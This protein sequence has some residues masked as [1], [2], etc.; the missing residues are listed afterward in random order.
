MFGGFYWHLR[1][2]GAGVLW[3]FRRR[4]IGAGP[5]DGP[6]DNP[7]GGPPTAS[8]RAGR[9]FQGNLVSPGRGLCLAWQRPRPVSLLSSRACV[10]CGWR[11]WRGAVPP[12][13]AGTNAL[14][15]CGAGGEERARALGAQG[16]A[17]ESED[18]KT[19]IKTTPLGRHLG[20]RARSLSSLSGEKMEWLALNYRPLLGDAERKEAGGINI[21]H[22]D[23]KLQNQ[24]GS[25]SLSAQ[26]NTWQEWPRRR[27]QGRKWPLP[28]S[29]RHVR[30]RFHWAGPQTS[31]TAT[32]T[33]IK[34]MW[35]Y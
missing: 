4:F 27:R 16:T 20:N 1:Q 28:G 18:V 21:L 3:A 2:D 5:P 35:F 9:D 6:P 32:P 7:P 31:R 30:P 13:A 19:Q 25:S 14:C 33:L 26:S 22:R 34:D 29:P 10:A 23:L 11:R 15:V 8:R 12:G 17:L 24:W